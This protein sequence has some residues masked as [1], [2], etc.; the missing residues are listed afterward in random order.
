MGY[1]EEI[2][3]NLFKVL[4]DPNVNHNHPAVQNAIDKL[5]EDA[6]NTCDPGMCVHALRVDVR[7]CVWRHEHRERAVDEEDRQRQRDLPTQLCAE[8][9]HSRCFSGAT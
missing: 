3:D 8:A 4:N 7:I 5:V 2:L 9:W 6:I 1:L